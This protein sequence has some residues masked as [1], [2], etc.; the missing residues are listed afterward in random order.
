MDR[1]ER[2]EIIANELQDKINYIADEYDITLTEIIGVLELLKI[3]A[4]LNHSDD[5][6]NK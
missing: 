6:D 3:N 4:F 2:I 1:Q 5:Y